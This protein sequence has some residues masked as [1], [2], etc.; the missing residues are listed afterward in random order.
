VANCGSL[1]QQSPLTC[2]M[3]SW[4]SSFM[5]SCRTP[6]NKAVLNL[7]S[8]TSHS[9]MLLVSLKSRC[10]IYLNGFPCG[11]RSRTLA[12]PTCLHE[13]PSE[14][15]VQ[16][17]LVKTRALGSGSLS[18]GPPG[19]LAGGVQSTMKLASTWLLIVWHDTKSS[20]NSTNSAVHLVILP[21]ALGLQSTT[22]RW[23]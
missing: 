12:P 20:S 23:V 13:E 2:L 14:K 5:R 10:T 4:E 17:G 19:W 9:T 18:S 16:L 1:Q 11:L 22:P 21:V 8:R 3:M 15:R 6:S 7:K